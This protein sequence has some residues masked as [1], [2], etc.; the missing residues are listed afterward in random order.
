MRKIT[1][2]ICGAFEGQ[3]SLVRGNSYTDGLALFLHGNKIAQHTSEGLMVSTAGWDTVTTRERLNGLRGVRVYKR[4]G[5]LILNGKKWD[6]AMTNIKE[7][8]TGDIQ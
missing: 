5:Q 7:W 4:R 6:G 2:E 8:G 3:Y 1:K